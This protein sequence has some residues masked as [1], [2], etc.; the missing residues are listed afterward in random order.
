MTQLKNMDGATE[1]T[2]RNALGFCMNLS[3]SGF[4]AS[5]RQADPMTPMMANS[6]SDSFLR[7]S[8]SLYRPVAAYPAT[9]LETA[10]GN[11]T[12]ATA[13]TAL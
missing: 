12:T 7:F 2:H 3:V 10:T 8:T 5:I 13:Y 6:L 1:R 4:A 9:S 11:P